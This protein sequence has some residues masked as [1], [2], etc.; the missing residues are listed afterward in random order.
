MTSILHGRTN[1]AARDAFLRDVNERPEI[2]LICGGPSLS[3]EAIQSIQYSNVF[4]VNH[5]VDLIDEFN[6]SNRFFWFSADATRV[7]ECSEKCKRAHSQIVAIHDY[8]NYRAMR[9]HIGPNGLCLLPR[10][11]IRALVTRLNA[12]A[13]QI[14]ENDKLSLPNISQ[15]LQIRYI[16]GG[17]SLLPLFALALSLSPDTVTIHGFDATETN[18]KYAQGLDLPADAKLT[19][20]FNRRQIGQMIH[21]IID[22]ASRS[23]IRSKIKN[24]SPCTQDILKSS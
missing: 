6:D 3:S 14:G 19:P 20:G 22:E 24:Y 10:T 13:E 7:N 16:L 12:A 23:G 18:V 1:K 21:K 9:S 4:F 2:A 8:R 15:S 5:T 17:T 11:N